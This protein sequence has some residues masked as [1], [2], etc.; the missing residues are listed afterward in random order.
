[1]SHF[2]H[3][4]HGHTLQACN[5]V[6]ERIKKDQ[7]ALRAGS[8]TIQSCP[9]CEYARVIRIPRHWVL[10]HPILPICECARI[11]SLINH[12]WSIP[13]PFVS[14]H[15]LFEY[16]TTGSITIKPCPICE[17]ACQKWYLTYGPILPHLRVCT[18]SSTTM[19]LVPLPSNP[20]PFVNMHVKSDI[21]RMVQSC[22]ICEYA[23]ILRFLCHW[24]LYHPILPLL[25]ACTCN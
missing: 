13:A 16:H 24:F 5:S 2:T 7:A 15:A 11:R 6:L 3:E 23:R 17:Y 14:M 4:H 20:A 12:V 10:Y 21:W 8:Y 22:P 1:M 25:W 18:H 9:I 19:P